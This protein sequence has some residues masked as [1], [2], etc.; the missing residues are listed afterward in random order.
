MNTSREIPEHCPACG[1][2]NRCSLA[3]PRT[4]DRQCWCFS[5]EIDPAILE[6]L[7]ENLR[8]K[9]CL[10]PRCAGQVEQHP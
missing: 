8:N 10:C 3:D 4:A 2:P 5:A 9:A 6:A 1:A 7:P